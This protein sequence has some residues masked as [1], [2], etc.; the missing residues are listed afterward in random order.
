MLKKFKQRF[1]ID[2][3]LFGSVKLTK[4]ANLDKYKFSGYS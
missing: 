2:N 1:Y 3:Y 4:N